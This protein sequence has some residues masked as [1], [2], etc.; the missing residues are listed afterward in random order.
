[1]KTI[2]GMYRASLLTA[3]ALILLTALP[4][5]AADKKDFD[6]HATAFHYFFKDGDMDFHFGSLVLGATVNGGAE[7]GEAFYAAS[8]IKDGDAADWQREWAEL[9]WRVEARG[10]K[11]LAAGH[12]VSARDQLLRAADYYRFS[13]ISMDPAN[14][15]FQERGAKVRKLMRQAGTLFQ[16]PLEYIEIPFEGVKLPG[17]FRAAAGKGA[18]KTLLM[19]G[20]GETFAE[21]LF[22]YIGPQ[23]HAHGYNFMTVDLP[24]QGLTPLTGKVFRPD[25][26]VPM[27][28]VVDYALSRP[29]V[30]PRGLAAYG[31]SG[32][33]AFVP[34]AAEFD[35]RLKAVAMNAA[36]VDAR[37]LFATMPAATDTARDKASWSAFHA[38]VVKAVCWRYGVPENEPA[39]LV[40]ANK[41]EGFDPAK[42]SVPALIIVGE[43]E[44]K[45]HE[46][47][48]QQKIAFDGFPN[49]AKKMVVTPADEGASNHCIM[50]NRSVGAQVLFDWLDG[51]LK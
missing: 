40:D 32:G 49:V 43:G 3:V 41:G 44:Y 26:N 20:G 2:I 13:L 11:S 28:A 22:F 5:L 1:V 6:A 31:I 18:H 47:K 12:K 25:E 4:V 16:Q 21:D 23:A 14:P 50:E 15:R 42:I 45:S 37:S 17:Y 9:A 34:Q 7:I 38:G 27:K 39:K 46:V 24:G 29:E 8:H 48:R 35:P 19:I 36:V 51:I 30:A 10:E 33:G